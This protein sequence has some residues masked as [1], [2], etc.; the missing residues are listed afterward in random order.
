MMINSLEVSRDSNGIKTTR[1]I[2]G[3]PVKRSFM[4]SNEFEKFT[5]NS[6]YQSQ[7]G[8]KHVMYYS[9]YA[10]DKSGDKVVVG[11]GFKGESQAKAAIRLIGRELGLQENN[12]TLARR[13]LE[14]SN[15]DDVTA[16]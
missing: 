6:K 15:K 3:I 9:V 13:A 12:R 2:L 16:V 8:G 7:G 5:K 4:H 1:R 11:E 14:S 10:V